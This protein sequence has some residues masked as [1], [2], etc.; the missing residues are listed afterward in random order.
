MAQVSLLAPQLPC[1]KDSC[2]AAVAVGGKNSPNVA[3]RK[4][5]CGVALKT[6]VQ[7]EK[8][9]IVTKTVTP[10]IFTATVTDA[11]V[12][13]TQTVDESQAIPN[14]E[15]ISLAFRT[16]LIEMIIPMRWKHEIHILYK[17]NDQLTHLH[18]AIPV[19]MRQHACAW[20]PKQRLL[21][22]LP[23]QLRERRL[24]L[25]LRQLRQYLLPRHIR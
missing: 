25:L 24:S 20:E 9:R 12:T 21:E 18:A 13:E 22:L 1:K 16:S 4:A 7:E 14:V 2:Y 3:S 8:T 6:I 15:P 19:T 23:K 17:A 10:A 11:T 5:D